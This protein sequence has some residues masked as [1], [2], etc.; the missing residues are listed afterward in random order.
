MVFYKS[1]QIVQ[2]SNSNP[3]S[4]SL[5]IFFRFS[6]SKY[7]NIFFKNL[8]KTYKLRRGSI[9]YMYNTMAIV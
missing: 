2:F 6:T 9:K 3:E 7:V 5:L 4:E 8:V 1:H